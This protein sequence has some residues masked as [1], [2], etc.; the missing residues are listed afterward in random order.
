MTNYRVP[1][2]SIVVNK[3]CILSY[4][5]IRI[6]ARKFVTKEICGIG[7]GGGDGWAVGGGGAGAGVK[8][9]YRFVV[10]NA[11]QGNAALGEVSECYHSLTAHQHQKGHTVPKQVIMQRQFKSLQSKNCTV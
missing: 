8:L 10:I 3:N 2:R 1:E 5:H 9:C 6:G 11:A 7:V 4:L